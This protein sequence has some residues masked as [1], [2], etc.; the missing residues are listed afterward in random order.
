M[1]Q[2][3]FKPASKLPPFDVGEGTKLG[4]S[5]TGKKEPT[6]STENNDRWIPPKPDS[7]DHYLTNYRNK[8]VEY[9]IFTF[10]IY[11]LYLIIYMLYLFL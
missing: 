11:M 10:Y 4:R 1:T 5:F 3:H 7:P 8:F 6:G 2:I 9:L